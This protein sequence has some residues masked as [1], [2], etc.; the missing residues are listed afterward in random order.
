MLTRFVIDFSSTI[1][2]IAVVAVLSFPAAILAQYQGSPVTQERLETVLRAKQVAT[3]QIVEII[4][5]KGVNFQLTGDTET[6]L[7]AAGARPQVIEAIRQNFRQETAAAAT[8]SAVKNTPVANAP[9]NNQV[10]KGAPLT[11]DAVIALLENG[12]ADAQVQK[13]VGAR[14]VAFQMNADIAKEIK[15]AGGSD[16]LVGTIF[17]AYI[18][19][20]DAEPQNVGAATVNSAE[21]TAADAYDELINR[22][23]DA[24]RSINSPNSPEI[25]R[26]IDLL[27]QAVALDPSNPRAYQGLGFAKMYATGSFGEAE[28]FFNQAVNLGGSAVVRVYHDHNGV[29]S[30][31]CEGSLYISKTAVRFESDDNQ[32]TF[33]TAKDSIQ[34]VKTNNPFKQMVQQIKG[35]Y[36]IVLKSEEKNGVKFSFAP[37]TQDLRESQLVVRLVGKN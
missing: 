6:R 19:A 20:A 11:K 5:K 25:G 21:K 26:T 28:G 29:F 33:E 17:G 23:L 1:K 16:Q 3:N 35:S 27:R 18:A 32:H 4:K 2:L 9:K 13:N 36:K 31:V 37:F 24:F 10:F 15:A 34:Q 7:T 14:G 12:V 30:D 22:S 8:N